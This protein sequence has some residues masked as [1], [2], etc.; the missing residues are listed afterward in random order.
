M[1]DHPRR[2]QCARQKKKK[3]TIC[4]GDRRLHGPSL[5]S[6]ADL[7]PGCRT[8]ER[9]RQDLGKR[10]APAA[11]AKARRGWF[12]EDRPLQT[13]RPPKRS[14]ALVKKTAPARAQACSW[15]DTIR[16]CIEAARPVSNRLR[17]P[18]R[19]AERPQRRPADV[20][21]SRSS[22]LPGKDWRKLHPQ[23][24]TARA[25]RQP[26]L[27]GGGPIGSEPAGVGPRPSQKLAPGAARAAPRDPAVWIAAT[28]QHRR[29]CPTHGPARKA[30]QYVRKPTQR[31][32]RCHVQEKSW[33]P[34]RPR[35]SGLGPSPAVAD[36]R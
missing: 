36:L 33:F 2:P 4:S 12:Y 35:G 31:E 6:W 16:G 1:S 5:G 28:D 17:R 27:A 34:D 9:T 25:F 26:P 24:G 22:I 20:R 23:G 29:A 10:V 7:A 32:G 3:K 18:S 13:P 8:A 21:P 11:L 19:P 14:I 30:W 15:S